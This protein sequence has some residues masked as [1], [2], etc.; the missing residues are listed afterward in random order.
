MD[1]LCPSLIPDYHDLP[2][3]IPWNK[4]NKP[5][6]EMADRGT[7]WEAGTDYA[8]DTVMVVG[9]NDKTIHQ[10]CESITARVVYFYEMR[11]SDASALQKLRGV[12]Q[13]VIN[14][15]TKL[16]DLSPLSALTRLKGLALIS[17]PKAT[18]L[19][20]IAALT[21]LRAFEFSGS[22]TLSSKNTA[23]TLAPLSALKRLEE[24]VIE[25]VKVVDGGIAPIA[26]CTTL[27]RLSL[28]N[29]FPVEDIAYLAAMLPNT[30]CSLF[31][32]SVPLDQSIRGHPT[33]S[34]QSGWDRMIVGRRKPF[35]NSEKD[36][37]RIQR[38]EEA[39]EALKQSHLQ[40]K[41]GGS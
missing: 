22:P 4:Q 20:P 5:L 18:D 6:L 19:A 37:T 25:G 30:S 32:G 26:A 9:A 14:W 39:F 27:K 34:A 36:A 40:T 17:T 29:S 33:G 31:R 13:I 41:N 7:R 35:L 23:Q 1:D 2:K 38:Y 16:V 28:S 21:D 8:S 24:L 15:N 10:I 11:V 12:E 3:H